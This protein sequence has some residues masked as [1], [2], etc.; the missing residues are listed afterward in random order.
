MPPRNHSPF[1]SGEF[2]T[3]TQCLLISTKICC[4]FSN[5]S[6]WYCFLIHLSLILNCPPDTASWTS[7]KPTTCDW[8]MSSLITHPIT[9]ARNLVFVSLTLQPP[10]EVAKRMGSA[11]SQT[12]R[13]LVEP[14]TTMTLGIQYFTSFSTISHL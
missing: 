7:H 11:R 9:R 10:G 3:P 8:L 14:L 4:Y 6:D 13:V 1:H 2:H 5:C 12:A